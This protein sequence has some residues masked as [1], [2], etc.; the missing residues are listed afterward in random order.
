MGI[1]QTVARLVVFGSSL[2]CGSRLDAHPPHESLEA[3]INIRSALDFFSHAKIKAPPKETISEETLKNI[4]GEIKQLDAND[5]KAR[6]QAIRKL[7]AYPLSTI[8]DPLAAALDGNISREQRRSIEQILTS[9]IFDHH[10]APVQNLMATKTNSVYVTED[11]HADALST[12][13]SLVAKRGNGVHDAVALAEKIESDLQR[14][15]AKLTVMQRLGLDIE[16]YP[17]NT[18]I[19]R[20]GRSLRECGPQLAE[21]HEKIFDLYLLCLSTMCTHDQLVSNSG[22]AKEISTNTLSALALLEVG[23]DETATSRFLAKDIKGFLDSV[24][25]LESIRSLT[26]DEAW[27]TLVRGSSLGSLLPILS[28]LENSGATFDEGLMREVAERIRDAALRGEVAILKAYE[29]FAQ[30]FEWAQHVGLGYRTPDGSRLVRF[31]ETELL[32]RIDTD[33]SEIEISRLIRLCEAV[34]EFDIDISDDE[35]ALITDEI[36][37][38]KDTRLYKLTYGTEAIRLILPKNGIRYDNPQQR[39]DMQRKLF[40][41]F[42]N[43]ST[44]VG[45]TFAIYSVAD[46]SSQIKQLIKTRAKENPTGLGAEI[47]SFLDDLYRINNA[48]QVGLSMYLDN[49]QAGKILPKDTFDNLVGSIRKLRDAKQSDDSEAALAVADQILELRARVA[50]LFPKSEPYRIVQQRGQVIELR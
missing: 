9:S 6:R 11:F 1:N 24:D 48:E 35:F 10:L 29:K 4:E 14:M 27:L 25:G 44:D 21:A 40:W 15:D 17:Q 3:P 23:S 36:S 7:T 42:V 20:F 31:I 13:R 46:A 16:W 2:A 38:G 33:R 50:K 18:I 28:R 39:D 5:I 19:C 41:H 12:L 26:R 37:A 32:R 45:Y 30:E 47:C 22:T 43:S 8:I 34:R 49:I